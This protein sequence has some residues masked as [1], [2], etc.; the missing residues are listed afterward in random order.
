MGGARKFLQRGLRVCKHSHKLWL[1]Y[2]RF[3][4]SYSSH[5]KARRDVVQLKSDE[6][7]IK[8][9]AQKKIVQ[10]SVA[11]LVFE[12]AVNKL[13]PASEARSADST[14]ALVQFGRKSFEILETFGHSLDVYPIRHKMLEIVEARAAH[15]ASYW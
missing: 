13:F 11:L 9:S 2:F 12:K 15:L 7:S 14:E 1:E 3:E 8:E 6:E 4:L 5:L 10:G